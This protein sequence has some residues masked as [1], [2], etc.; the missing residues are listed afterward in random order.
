[1]LIGEDAGAPAGAD[2]GADG[3][4]GV[5]DAEGEDGDQHQGDLGRV[6]EQGGQALA[7][8]DGAEGGGQLLAGL[9][10]ADGVAQGGDPHGD[11]NDGGGHDADED[12][13][14]YVEHQQHDGDH[15][16]D[17]EQP[18]HGGVQGGHG[19]HAGAKVYEAHVQKADVGHEDA[20]A[21]ANGVL[22]AAG[23]GL[24]DELTDL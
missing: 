6:R 16:A 10:K 4:E 3:V 20:D 21:A 17:D 23:D 12:G 2:K 14:L 19:G 13:A 1:V 18:Q 5:G 7:G 24:D 15:Q 9:G 22:Q 8:E 11:A